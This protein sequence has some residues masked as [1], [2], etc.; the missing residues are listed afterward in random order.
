MERGRLVAGVS[1]AKA[2][3]LARASKVGVPRYKVVAG[4]IRK[5][6][7]MLYYLVSLYSSFSY[8]LL[9]GFLDIGR[10]RQWLASAR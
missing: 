5:T 7:G 9:H 4:A 1:V 8:T 2:K 6:V 10:H 3:G